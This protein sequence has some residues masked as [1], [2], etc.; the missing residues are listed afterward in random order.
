MNWIRFFQLPSWLGIEHIV[1]LF[2]EVSVCFSS[3][4]YFAKKRRTQY[5][6]YLYHFSIW[7]GSFHNCSSLYHSKQLI[8]SHSESSIY[9]I[10]NQEE[11]T[12]CIVVGIR[13]QNATVCQSWQKAIGDID[14]E[15][16]IRKD[17]S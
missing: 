11:Q 17:G 2:D 12:L 4:L 15:K 10:F 14:K 3:D 13:I 16:N 5:Q 1:D 8:F 7:N 9:F 6:L